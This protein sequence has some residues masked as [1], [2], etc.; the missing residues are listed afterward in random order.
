MKKIVSSITQYIFIYN[1][2][3]NKMSIYLFVIIVF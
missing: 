2:R 3:N 1:I